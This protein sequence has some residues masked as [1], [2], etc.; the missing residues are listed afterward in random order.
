M[1]RSRNRRWSILKERKLARRRGKKESSSCN[2]S[3]RHHQAK[4]VSTKF[5]IIVTDNEI[6]R[7]NWVLPHRDEKYIARDIWDLGKIM[8]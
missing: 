6:G 8:V 5:D 4:N 1:Q 7:R 3:Q 2:C